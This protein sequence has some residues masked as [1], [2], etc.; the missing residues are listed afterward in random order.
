MKVTI[1]FTTDN[2]AFEDHFHE[3][4]QDIQYQIN[5]AIELS[6]QPQTNLFDLNGNTIGTIT[7][8]PE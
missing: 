6:L 3:Q 8:T 7:L 5:R 2:A 1:T 4:L